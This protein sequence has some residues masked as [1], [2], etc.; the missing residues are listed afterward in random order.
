MVANMA[1][2]TAIRLAGKHPFFWVALF[3]GVLLGT[4]KPDQRLARIAFIA[5]ASSALLMSGASLFSIDQFFH[6]S[7][8]FVFFW[9]FGLD[10][11]GIGITYHVF[12][13]FPSGPPPG[14]VW[15]WIK[16]T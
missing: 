13:L 8:R 6:G 7:E 2:K 5:S 11:F 4:L 14:R 9:T 12:Y 16:R 1:I 3:I 15:A 10:T